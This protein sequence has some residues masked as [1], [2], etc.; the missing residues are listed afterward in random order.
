MGAK[1]E[2]G[3]CNYKHTLF[4]KKITIAPRFVI[5]NQTD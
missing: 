3:I 1:I 5:V 4:N 2:L